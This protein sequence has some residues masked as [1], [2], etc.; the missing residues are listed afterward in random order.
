METVEPDENNVPRLVRWAPNL[1]NRA[2]PLDAA[3]R[4]QNAA[5]L[6]RMARI[7]ED[8]RFEIYLARSSS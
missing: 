7:T 8:D 6:A 2:L 5:E 3:F 1:A 4:V